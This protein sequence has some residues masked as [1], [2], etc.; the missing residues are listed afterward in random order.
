MAALLLVG[1][2]VASQGVA[3]AAHA[4]DLTPTSYASTVLAD[5]PA[6]FYQFNETGGSTAADSSGNGI[7]GTYDPGVTLGVPGPIASDPASSA[8]TP[9]G[10]AVD[11]PNTDLPSGYFAVVTYEFWAKG[12]TDPA[13]GATLFSIPGATAIQIADNDGT[14]AI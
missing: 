6:A 13:T 11:V 7:D 1:S 10:P 4:A 12:T 5:S 8:V 14:T 9:S 3:G 2:L